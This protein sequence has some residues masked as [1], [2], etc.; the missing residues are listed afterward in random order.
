[1][2]SGF[3]ITTNSLPSG[4][5][6]SSYKTTLSA[7]G[8]VGAYAWSI[9]SGVLPAGLSLKK[10]TGV[11]SGTPKAAST[12]TLT[13][14]VSDSARPANVAT[15]TLTLVIVAIP[16]AITTNSLPSGTVKKNYRATLTASGGVGAYT[17]SITSGVL[18]AGLSLKSSTG[19]IS[20]IPR[21]ASTTALTFEVTDSASPANVAT[22]TLTLVIST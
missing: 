12:T 6:G 1:M 8:G 5:V 13:F 15:K 21:A 2:G 20:G 19:L 4:S 10:T 11:L 17:W 14:E 18:P 16:L 9:T 7:S 3:A 22:K